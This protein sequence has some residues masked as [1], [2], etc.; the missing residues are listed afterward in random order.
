LTATLSASALTT[1][2]AVQNRFRLDARIRFE[3]GH[4]HYG[5]LTLDQALDVVQQFMFIDAH[6]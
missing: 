1:I 5:D 4:L 2:L 6:Q 3:S